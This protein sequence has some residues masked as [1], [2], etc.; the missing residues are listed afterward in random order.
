MCMCIH[1]TCNKKNYRLSR[2]WGYNGT[3][4]GMLSVLA[5]HYMGMGGKTKSFL[6][7]IAIILRNSGLELWVTSSATI[8]NSCGQSRQ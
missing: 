2:K 1:I 7:N 3:L 4:S 6:K 5:L 8:A